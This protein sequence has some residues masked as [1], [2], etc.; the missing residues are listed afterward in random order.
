MQTNLV[1]NNNPA[2]DKSTDTIYLHILGG[3]AALG[4]AFCWAV[5]AV[6]FQQVGENISAIAMNLVKGLVAIVCIGIVLLPVG[7]AEISEE[8]FFIL[9]MS[10]LVGI[11]LGDTLYFLT[12]NRLGSRITLLIGT[13]IP[14]ATALIALTAL[15]ESI[16]GHAAIGLVLTIVG[17]G[18]VLWERTPE[19]EHNEKWK[20]GVFFGLLFV[21]AN[22]FG[23]IFTKVGVQDIPAMDATLVR[24]VWAVIG[25]AAWGMIT[26]SFVGWVKPMSDSR[27]RNKLLIAS[28]IGA[29]LGTWLS[30]VALKYT[31]AVVATTLN[32]TSPL[33]VLPLAMLFLKEQITWRAVSGAF[34]AIMGVAIYF[35]SLQW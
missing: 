15:G 23:I 16:D 21:L 11:C 25:L 28:V 29:F 20:L 35:F 13:L 24:T 6:L 27:L 2:E 31:H 12:I 10:G 1:S 5:S 4:S 19:H 22:A 18:Y 33:F 26:R 30:V 3:L 7:F 9:A 14:V 8:A 17:V 32:S 34:I